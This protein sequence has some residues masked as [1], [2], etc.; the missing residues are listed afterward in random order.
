VPPAREVTAADWSRI[1]THAVCGFAIGCFFACFCFARRSSFRGLPSIHPE[2]R[3]TFV[4]GI[5]LVVSGL[6]GWYGDEVCYPSWR[7]MPR[8][9]RHSR[10]SRILC[11]VLLALGSYMFVRALY[12]HLT[13]W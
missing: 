10:A 6:F 8:L 5:A 3:T 12:G 2:W 11:G 13:T 7:S 9:V 4:L 1:A